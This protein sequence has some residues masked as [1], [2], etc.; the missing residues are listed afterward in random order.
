M[1]SIARP[2][3]AQPTSA[4]LTDFGLT[5]GGGGAGPSTSHPSTSNFGDG[6]P[7]RAFEGYGNYE[8]E[9]LCFLN[10]PAL[11]SIG[12][13]PGFDADFSLGLDSPKEGQSPLFRF[14]ELPSS[15]LDQAPEYEYVSQCVT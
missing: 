6:L 8:G 10:D 12:V 7:T 4:R 13:L 14:P 11:D 15:L 9:E 5:S 1:T 3:S 2:R